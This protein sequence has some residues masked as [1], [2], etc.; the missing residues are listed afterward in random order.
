V[1]K[2]LERISARGFWYDGFCGT[3]TNA[4]L[5]RKLKLSLLRTRAIFFANRLKAAALPKA[6][7][8]ACASASIEN[9]FEMR[10]L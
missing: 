4:A 1:Q 7:R 8:G 5:L 6:K 9:L 2:R 10:H 3:L